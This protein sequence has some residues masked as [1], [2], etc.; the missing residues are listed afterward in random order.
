MN[1]HYSKFIKQIIFWGRTTLLAALA[2]S[3]IPGLYLLVFHG[4]FPPVES[5]MTAMVLI[6]GTMVTSWR[7]EPIAYFPI[8][9]IS[10]TYM[11]WLA[12]NIGNVRVPV[13]SIA[14]K[15]AEVQE[16]SP[17]GDIVSTL[18]VGVSVIIN[19][20]ILIFGVLFGVPLVAAL[21]PLLKTML[22]YILPAVFGAVLAS[23]IV[24]SPLLGFIIFG[25]A[26]LMTII[27]APTWV[28][29]IV[30]VFGGIALG[31]FM[32]NQK[33]KKNASRV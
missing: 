4:I 3:F 33:A 29:L 32:F 27:G 28:N 6:S 8:L 21:P 16:G 5:L 15:T 1:E 10:G 23:F 12:G 24:R 7:T 18:G 31:I 14:Q 2:C 19:L 20:A 26:C 9:G 13:S 11:S 30:C 22:G 25:A 17:E